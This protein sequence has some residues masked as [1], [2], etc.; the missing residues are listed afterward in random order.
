M[1]RDY[2]KYSAVAIPGTPFESMPPYS[3]LLHWTSARKSVCG[4][5]NHV[6]RILVILNRMND[7]SRRQ[8]IRETF[9]N[10]TIS[11]KSNL[12]HWRKLFLVGAPQSV[13]DTIMLA[14]ENKL[15]KDIVVTNVTE[16]YYNKPTLKML[17]GLKFASCYC[18]QAEYFV[19]IDDDVY[20][21]ADKID[22][23]IKIQEK[24]AS[25]SSRKKKSPKNFYLGR[26]NNRTVLRDGKWGVPVSDYPPKKYPPYM[27]GVLYVL[28]MT[29]VHEMALDCPYTCIGLDPRDNIKNRDA[30]CFWAFED[31]FIGSCVHFIQKN[32]YFGEFVLLRR[33]KSLL[34]YV[35][36][37][38]GYRSK[39]RDTYMFEV[40]TGDLKRLHQYKIHE[41]FTLYTIITDLLQLLF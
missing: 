39:M 19:K 1:Q 18:G 24:N 9:G 40:K 16:G 22:D 34:A 32:S 21:E 20:F 5:S 15:F 28:S 2:S 25:F 31:I 36:K 14:N 38:K 3:N 41:P 27:T 7:S 6:T 33:W 23:A 37:E 17:I 26:M 10:F 30:N 13:E 35:I 11:K 8:I 29:A 12:S 4:Y